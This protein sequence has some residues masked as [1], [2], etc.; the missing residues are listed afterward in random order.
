MAVNIATAKPTATPNPTPTP[1]PTDEP[2]SFRIKFA[3]KFIKGNPQA[4]DNYYVSENVNL[5]VSTTTFADTACHV[6]DIYIA[7]IGH[8]ITAFGEDK[9][10]RSY[11]EHPRTFAKRFKALVTLSGD[12]YGARS[13]GVVI[14]NGMLYRDKAS[15]RDVC[16]L[17]WDG[18]MKTFSPRNFDAETEMKNGAYQAWNF[19]PALLDSQGNAKKEFNTDVFKANPR[20]A[21]GYFEPGHYCFVMVE[22]RNEQTEGLTMAQLSKFMHNLGCTQAYNLDGGQSATMVKLEDTYGNPVN[23][24][25]ELSDVI[26]VL[27]YILETE[28]AQ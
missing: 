21:I 8:L 24:G 2:G 20:A 12:Y 10:G 13:D 26:M 28:G 5:T 18:S 3:S 11:T 27:D 9:F 25:R 14:R 15:S 23:G 7:D 1:E 4:S 19:G 22:G 6:A 17:Y 16:V